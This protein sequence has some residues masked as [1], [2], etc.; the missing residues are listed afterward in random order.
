M[1]NYD[2]VIQAK[3]FK[4]K[5]KNPIEKGQICVSSSAICV[6]ICIDSL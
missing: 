2:W 6:I 3:V 5:E 4:K 1:K